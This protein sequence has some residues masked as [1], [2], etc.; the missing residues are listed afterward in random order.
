[1]I[2]DFRNRLLGILSQNL[3]RQLGIRYDIV[4]SSMVKSPTDDVESMIY[5]IEEMSKIKS[6]YVDAS[7]FILLS[8]F[9]MV[10]SVTCSRKLY[11]TMAS[12]NQWGSYQITMKAERLYIHDIVVNV[13]SSKHDVYDPILMVMGQIPKKGAVTITD[14]NGFINVVMEGFHLKNDFT[15]KK[16]QFEILNKMV[17]NAALLNIKSN[18]DNSMKYMV[19]KQKE[20]EDMVDKKIH[21][22]TLERFT[23]D[24]NRFL[25]NAPALPDICEIVNQELGLIIS[26]RVDES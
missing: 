4:V 10:K 25:E 7:I 3:R 19:D 14:F 22:I 26:K 16:A 24:L 6:S 1:V 12:K 11:Q 20:I 18:I 2:Q 21:E 8:N 5:I 13:S 17:G 23:K 15:N 9:D